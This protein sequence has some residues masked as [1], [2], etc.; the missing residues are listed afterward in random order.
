VNEFLQLLVVDLAVLCAMNCAPVRAVSSEL[1]LPPKPIVQLGYSLVPLN[2][3]G[4]GV[5][6]RTPTLLVLGKRGRGADDTLVV[7]AE[8][9]ES[10]G[11][12]LAAPVDEANPATPGRFKVL[13]SERTADERAT[14]ERYYVLTEDGAPKRQTGGSGPMMLETMELRCVHPDDDSVAISLVYS[15]R[16]EPGA[17]DAAFDVKAAAL[18]KGMQFASP[19]RLAKRDQHAR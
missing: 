14:C 4:W 9:R 1:R 16:Y 10:T 17:R 6:R 13:K 15:E 8:S 19:G 18:L 7:R 5:L 2:E 3:R 11:A 12:M